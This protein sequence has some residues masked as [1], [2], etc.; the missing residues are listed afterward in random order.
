MR[1][2]TSF[3]WHKLNHQCDRSKPKKNPTH[4][5]DLK[6]VWSQRLLDLL[7]GAGRLGDRS[8]EIVQHPLERELLHDFTTIWIFI[9]FHCTIIQQLECLA[10]NATTTTAPLSIYLSQITS[11]YAAKVS[12]CC[13]GKKKGFRCA[14]RSRREVML[15]TPAVKWREVSAMPCC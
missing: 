12:T 2:H 9:S 3:I 8:A 14:C 1:S 10:A 5:L 11:F 4:P 13:A 7:I 6:I 15:R